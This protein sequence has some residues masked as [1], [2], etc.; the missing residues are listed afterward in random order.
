M[1]HEDVLDFIR[2]H[3]RRC[4]PPTA[5][6]AV[7]S[8][9]RSLATVDAERSRR[10]QH[11]RDRGEDAQ[12]ASATRAPACAC[13]NDGFF[14][15]WHVVEGTVEIVRL[16]EAMEPLVDY[17]RRAVGE[18]PDW[19][20]VPRRDGAG[21]ARSAAADGA[22]AAARAGRGSRTRG[23][24]RGRYPVAMP[25][26][27]RRL[28]AALT[29]VAVD[30]GALRESKAFRRLERGPAGVAGGA[31]D[32]RGRGAVPGVHDHALARRWSGCSDSPRWCR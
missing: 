29:G 16:P 10:G 13:S 5:G 22:S 14:G 12:P 23:A 3:T 18:H 19:D 26:A 9:L 20:R 6:T 24:R 25:R 8:S 11:A 27:G 32:H 21:A 7:P 15:E 2:S 31:A 1:A 17:Y 4:S 30:I 28:S